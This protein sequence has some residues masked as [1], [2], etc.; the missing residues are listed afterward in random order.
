MAAKQRP[1]EMAR[2][3]FASLKQGELKPVYYLFGEESYLLDQAVRA[4]IKVAAP[5][6]L[7]AFNS[8]QFSG[9]ETSGAAVRSAGASPAN[10]TGDT[11]RRAK[12][13]SV[14]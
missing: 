14:P 4:L 10:G 7:N 3:F 5:D 2:S 11:P 13:A 9:K 8:D 12:K 1:S 6:G